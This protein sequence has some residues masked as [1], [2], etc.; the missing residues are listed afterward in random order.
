MSSYNF[1]TVTPEI[2]ELLPNLEQIISFIQN[3]ENKDIISADIDNL[4]AGI[5]PGASNIPN[6][7][8]LRAINPRE[9]YL[10]LYNFVLK[11]FIRF[12]K[13]ILKNKKHIVN[14][15]VVDFATGTGLTSL[16]AAKLGAQSVLGTDARQEYIDIALKVREIA[17]IGDPFL[18]FVV[19]DINNHQSNNEL[20]KNADTVIFSGIMAHVRSHDKIL[21]SVVND[22]SVRTI[23]IE[24]WDS[25]S[26]RH[27]SQPKVEK[28]YEP[29]TR[30]NAINYGEYVDSVPVGRP[31]TSWFKKMANNIGFSIV[32]QHYNI[33]FDDIIIRYTDIPVRTMNIINQ[34]EINVRTIHTLTKI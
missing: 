32:S 27:D 5:K 17:N 34:E 13:I 22:T 19:S 6:S 25:T 24:T 31:N 30:T 18:N 2:L 9:N 8:Y 11:N 33:S 23:I 29:V 20:C 26:V 3:S 1:N 16:L 28:F 4:T 10:Y 7:Q 14:K 15:N 21:H 12:D